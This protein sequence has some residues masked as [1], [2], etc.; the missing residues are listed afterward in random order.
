MTKQV[1]LVDD[2]EHILRLLDYHLSKE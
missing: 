2:E 1:L